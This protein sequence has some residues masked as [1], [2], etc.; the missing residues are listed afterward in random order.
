MREFAIPGKA[1]T[2]L[3]GSL[4]DDIVSNANN[5]PERVAFSRPGGAGWQPVTSV[6]FHE[7][8]RRIAKG[9]IAAG[10][11][12]G[13][14][15]A[16]LSRTRYEWTLV[17]YALWYVGAVTVPIYETSSSAPD[18]VDPHRLRRGRDRRGVGRASRPTRRRA[19][20]AAG[21]CARSG[22]STTAP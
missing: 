11:E 9:L 22:P 2:P 5:H 6:A 15:V 17:D 14:R 18:R 20:V 3:D 1:L 12:P 7:Q 10:I 4:T 16:L 21:P 19:A 8:V 13:D